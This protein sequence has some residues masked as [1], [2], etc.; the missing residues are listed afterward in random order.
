MGTRSACTFGALGRCGR[1]VSRARYHWNVH[2]GER[3]PERGYEQ[4]ARP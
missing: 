3:A 4:A 2:A 1:V